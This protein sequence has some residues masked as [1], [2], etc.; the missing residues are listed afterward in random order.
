MNHS[1]EQACCAIIDFLVDLRDKGAKT[2]DEVVAALG[3]LAEINSHDFAWD[4]LQQRNQRMYDEVQNW[5]LR[6]PP[7][8]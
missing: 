1:Y 5:V 4:H 3:H 7:E 6:N 8:L 2:Q